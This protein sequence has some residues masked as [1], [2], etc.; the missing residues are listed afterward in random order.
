MTETRAPRTIRLIAADE[1]A[2]C[3]RIL[4]ALPD[5]FGIE[6]SIVAYRRDIEKMETWVVEVDRVVIGFVTVNVHNEYATEIQVMAVRP[7]HHGRGHGRALVAQAEQ[8][9]RSRS[10]EYLHVKTLGPSHPSE[11]YAGT[12]HFYFEVG[13]RPLE[14]HRLWGD[15]NP[16]LVMVKRL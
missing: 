13:F 8:A 4:R 10:F 12:R 16:C 7:E 5:W 15:A 6:S 1:A 3:E 9:L 2:E 14:E 11:H